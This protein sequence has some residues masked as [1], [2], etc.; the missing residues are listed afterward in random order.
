MQQD[1]VDPR[2][3]PASEVF[4]RPDTS[5]PLQASVP[6]RHPGV[7]KNKLTCPAPSDRHALTANM[8]ATRQRRRLVSIVRSRS[9]AEHPKHQS[10]RIPVRLL[11]RS[12]HGVATIP[13]GTQ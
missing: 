11:M 2:T 12:W 4:A 5:L 6:P 8:D 10:T 1:C 3:G 7:I 9:L 13:Q